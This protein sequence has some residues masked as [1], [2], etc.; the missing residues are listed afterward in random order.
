MEEIDFKEFFYSF[1]KKIGL[2]IC[3]TLIGLC[4]GVIY[5]LFFVTPM[6]KSSITLVLAKSGSETSDSSITQSD[7]TLNQKLLS[8]YSEIIR[9]RSVAREV[10]KDLNIQNMTIEQFISNISVNSKEGTEIMQI[11]VKNVDPELAAKFAT[12]LSISFTKKVQEVYKIDNVSVIDEAEIAAKPFNMSFI[13][14]AAI[15]TAGSFA[16]I[17][18][19][20]FLMIYFNNTVRDEEE[21]ERLLNL[22]VIAIIPKIDD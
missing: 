22:N 13:K 8:T 14:N 20:I 9:S 1:K 11:T 18:G 19:I 7:I 3:V 2:I 15:F 5:S 6:Y 4:I 12:A 21:I 16:L 10:I 17:C